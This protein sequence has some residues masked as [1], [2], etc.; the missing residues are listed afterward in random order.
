MCLGLE[1]SDARLISPHFDGWPALQV[2]VASLQHSGTIQTFTRISEVAV[3]CISMLIVPPEPQSGC[4]VHQWLLSLP[5]LGYPSG[6]P[7]SVN[8]GTVLPW[9]P[10]Y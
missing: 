6:R 9:P 8:I 4:Q 3:S 7:L 10:K 5:G 1:R 2:G